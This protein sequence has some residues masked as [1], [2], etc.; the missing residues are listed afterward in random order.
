[1]PIVLDA[2]VA[3]KLIADEDGAEAARALLDDEKERIAPD[4]MLV[5]VASGLANKMRFEGLAPDLA[6][7]KLA[8]LPVFIDRFIPCATLINETMILSAGLDHALYDCF[9]LQVALQEEGIVITADDGF[10][11]AAQRA[12]MGR[13]VERLT[14]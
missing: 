4:W 12:G 5:E 7:S 14:W 1:M 8:A 6:S 3:I 13:W 11:K 10:A 9:Y 2:S